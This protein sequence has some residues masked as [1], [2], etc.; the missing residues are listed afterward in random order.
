MNWFRG[1]YG[2]C[3]LAVLSACG[4]TPSPPQETAAETEPV[5]SFH[6]AVV[7][8]LPYNDAQKTVLYRKITPELSAYPFVIHIGDYKAGGG[9]PC[10]DA[11]DDEHLQ[12]MSAASAPV[13]YTPGDNEWTD[14]DR[15]SN[16][17]EVRE[18]LR[19]QKLRTKFFTPATVT[20][21]AAWRAEW[22]PVMPENASWVFNDVRFATI[23][24]VGSNNGRDGLE[25]CWSANPSDCDTPADIAAAVAM[26]DKNNA[27]WI[28]SVFARA[29]AETA[30]A[31]VLATQ[32]DV[33]DVGNFFGKD[34]ATSGQNDCDGF[35]DMRRLIAAEAAAFSK[36]VLLI[37]GDSS[38][39]C[40]DKAFGGNAASNLWRLN[41]AGDYKVI[42][43]VDMTVAPGAAAPFTAEGVVTKQKPDAAC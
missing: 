26:R 25:P 29:R 18:L 3:F 13:F 31:I 10:T 15:K 14:C 7:G 5:K 37:H 27:A 20:P 36:P 19:L 11:V 28:K 30:E 12:W 17:P 35:K 41:A 40:W 21:P 6:F 43:G 1:A 2:F 34:C 32:A 42:D 9:A 23:H 33:T 22:Q 8:D 16:R 39:F 38:P 24:L 4:S